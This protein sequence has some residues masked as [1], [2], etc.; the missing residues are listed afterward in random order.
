ML[1]LCIL[2]FYKDMKNYDFKIKLQYIEPLKQNNI[3]I[4]D[5]AHGLQNVTLSNWLQRYFKEKSKTKC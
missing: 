2:T 3:N 5:S 4:C 1:I